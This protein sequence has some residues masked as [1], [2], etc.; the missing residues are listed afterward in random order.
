[1]SRKTQRYSKEFKAEAVRT[2]LENQLSISEG[3]SRLSLP[4][5]TLGQW[6]TAARKGLGTLGSRTLA[7][8]ESEILQLR[9]ALNEARLE[10]DIFKKSNSVFC[11]GVAEKYALI[12][13]WR[14]QFPI[15]AMC[16]VF[17]V[18]RSGYYNWVQHEPSD[19]KQSDER[20]KPEIKVAHI[21]TRETY[22]T[23]RL[24]TE[25]AENGIIVGRDRLARLRKELRLRCKQKRK[26]RATTNPNHNLPVAPNLLNQTFAPT[27]PNQV[28]VADLTYVATQEGWLY[29]AGIKDVYT[30][31]IVGYAMGERMTK[32]LTGK[33][34]FMALRSQRPPAGLIHHSDRGSQYCAYDYRV[35]Q[36]QSGLKTSMSRKGNCYD[37]AP[38]ESFW[39]TLKNESLSHYRFNNRDEA[40]SVIRE[41]IEIFYN[42]QRRHSR[43]GNISPAAFREKYHQMTA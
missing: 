32:E 30:C 1:M 15:E 21:R 10:R 23:R 35:I 22:G 28:W 18:S 6:V 26:F 31:E 24:Q 29:L 34:L 4:E 16:Q 43:L 17:G 42:R 37:N 13:Q 5:G 25:L 7:E 12:E 39:G 27:A 19:R 40:I 9:K 8:L 20:L 41:Y 14:Q 38:M 36:E 2:V 11:T 3:A 33:A